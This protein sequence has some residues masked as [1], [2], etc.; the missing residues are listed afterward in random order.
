M[1]SRLCQTNLE[2][3]IGFLDKGNAVSLVYL[4][5]R[6]ASDI[7]PYGRLLL[8][9]EI[10]GCNVESWPDKELV[11]TIDTELYGKAVFQVAQ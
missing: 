10:M 11:K 9:L 2:K 6:K 4:D 1:E 5:F 7:A 3:I 8:K